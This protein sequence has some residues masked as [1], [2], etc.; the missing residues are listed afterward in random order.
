VRVGDRNPALGIDG[1]DRGPDRAGLFRGDREPDSARMQVAT[2]AWLSNAESIRAST[3]P[4][5]PAARAVL[6]ASATKLA[7]RRCQIVCVQDQ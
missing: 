5:A 7:A 3:M 6:M 2:T 4:V 1:L